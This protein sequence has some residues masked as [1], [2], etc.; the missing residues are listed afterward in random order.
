MKSRFV[1]TACLLVVL[2]GC[3]ERGGAAGAEVAAQARASQILDQVAGGRPSWSHY[4]SEIVVADGTLFGL[5]IV[6]VAT[7][8]VRVLTKSS[9]HSS[10]EWSPTEDRVAY[11][12]R[13]VGRLFTIDTWGDALPKELLGGPLELPSEPWSPDGRRLLF[14]TIVGLGVLDLAS[15]EARML[16]LRDAGDMGVGRPQWSADS[17]QVIGEKFGRKVIVIDVEEGR[18]E[19]LGSVEGRHPMFGSDGSLWVLG[20]AQATQLL[21][22]VANE[23]TAIEGLG[24]P[25]RS[26]DVAARTGDVVAAVVGR[27]LALIGA[28][29][30]FKAW[31]TEGGHHLPR[32]SPDGQSIAFVDQVGGLWVVERPECALREAAR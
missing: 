24:G 25:V 23:R 31:L 16:V 21:R 27:G 7:G 18:A 1:G 13:S 28:D 5:R 3:V 9:R 19:V 32:W 12:D 10:P 2:A 22:Y 20:G 6:S 11:V 29:G 26:F 4:G 8:Q 17:R 14:S 30:G 15:G